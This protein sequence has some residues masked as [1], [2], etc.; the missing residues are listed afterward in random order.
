LVSNL[1]KLEKLGIYAFTDVGRRRRAPNPVFAAMFNP[2]SYTQSFG[3]LWSKDAG[4]NASSVQV[5]YART[6]PSDLKLDLV[7]DGTGVDEMG[8][9]ALS[10]KTVRERV[11]DF[12]DVT[13]RY[14]G[15]IHEPNYLLA[16][17]GSLI[18]YCRLET[19]DIKYTS[20][21][22]DG[23]PLRAEL[24]VT[25]I[26]DQSAEDRARLEAKQSPDVTHTRVVRSGDTLPLL[27]KEIY[28]SPAPYLL[29]ARWNG[30]DDFRMLTPGARIEF[31][32]LAELGGVAGASEGG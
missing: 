29:V 13:Y 32:P 28:G 12:L 16:Q 5:N 26:S 14:N 31:P 27:T 1:F 30:L 4:I 25:L 3:I 18:F 21:H 11:Q 15:V 6:L 20:F 22:R 8:V 10:R 24:T 19:V 17:W 2:A 7:L 23:T 9:V